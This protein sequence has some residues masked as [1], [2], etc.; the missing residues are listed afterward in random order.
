MYLAGAPA[1]DPQAPDLPERSFLVGTITVPQVGG[2]P[3]TVNRNPSVFVAAGGIQP[4]SSQ[5][6]Q[7]ALVPYD[8]MRIDRTDLDRQLRYN[9]T[10]WVGGKANIG[11]DGLYVAYGA[12]NET[13]LVSQNADG[14]VI[15]EGVLQRATGTLTMLANDP[16]PL[17]TIPAGFRPTKKRTFIVLTSNAMGGL[18]RI[19]ID[20]T[21]AVTWETPTAFTSIPAASAVMWLDGHTWSTS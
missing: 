6:A 9:G 4:V 3:P 10:R 17:A 14:D 13:P 11:L 21:G 1:A 7:D 18:A 19:Y 12:G 8:G 20:P 5:A 15:L 2:G 16:K